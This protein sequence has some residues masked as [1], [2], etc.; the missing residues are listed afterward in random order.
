MDRVSAQ[1]V[2]EPGKEMTAAKALE[3]LGFKVLSVS[4][5]IFLEGE[6]SLFEEAFGI[7]LEALSKKVLPGISEG[8]V[9]NY[10]RK[11]GRITL[12]GEVEGLVQDLVF[13]EPP[14]FFQ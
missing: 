14:E 3:R 13:P 9:R 1:A 7:R 2:P 12:P 10:W 5:V 6:R 11:T 8:S 4:E